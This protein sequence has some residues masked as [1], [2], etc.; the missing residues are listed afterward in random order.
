MQLGQLELLLSDEGRWSRYQ[1]QISRLLS[2]QQNTIFYILLSGD[3]NT[4]SVAQLAERALRMREAPGSKPGV[5]I[6]FITFNESKYFLFFQP[7]RREKRA[8]QCKNTSA[9]CGGRTHDHK[10]KSLALC[11][12]S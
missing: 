8:V 3:G 2:S 1:A 12:L 7:G 11:Q 4:G 6:L 9:R 5:S 10:V